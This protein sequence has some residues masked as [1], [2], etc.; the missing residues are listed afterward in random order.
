MDISSENIKYCAKVKSYLGLD[1]KLS[2][3]ETNPFHQQIQICLLLLLL[4]IVHSSWMWKSGKFVLTIS[5]SSDQ[6][7]THLHKRFQLNFHFTFKLIKVLHRILVWKDIPRQHAWQLRNLTIRLG[8]WREKCLRASNSAP[9]YE[10]F[11]TLTSFQ[12]AWVI[13]SSST[14]RNCSIS[15]AFQRK[16]VEFSSKMQ[17]YSKQ[18]RSIQNCAPNSYFA[19]FH[20]FKDTRDGKLQV[21][22]HLW[23][24][25]LPGN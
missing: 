11:P 21:R 4:L 13:P 24:H 18:I 12:T 7:F 10:H 16:N 19:L 8:D 1:K 17:F 25:G 14:T 20:C 22:M 2:I 5:V 3:K 15:E 6:E 9:K 23:S